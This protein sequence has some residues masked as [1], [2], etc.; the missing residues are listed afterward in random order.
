MIFVSGQSKSA[1]KRANKRQAKLLAEQG[2]SNQPTG[3]AQPAVP[4]PSGNG[5]PKRK[6]E[7][8]PIQGNAKK[9]KLSAEQLPA[10]KMGGKQTVYG[11]MGA[12]EPAVTQRTFVLKGEPAFDADKR[13]DLCAV[14]LPS[15]K[16]KGFESLADCSLTST[17]KG[18]VCT[19]CKSKPNG[20]PINNSKLYILGDQFIP[21]L[22]GGVATACPRPG[23]RTPAS[24]R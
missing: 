23:W 17:H 14:S 6:V 12:G 13:N 2:A 24:K 22:V 10:L 15:I 11:R 20:H 19:T 9:I 3:Q 21:P 7:V 16:D 5:V 18:N 8:A 1:R 4:L